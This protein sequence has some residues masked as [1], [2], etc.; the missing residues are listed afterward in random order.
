MVCGMAHFPAIRV[1]EATVDIRRMESAGSGMARLTELATR[2][3]E[4]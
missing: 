3:P 4:A 1:L 2:Q